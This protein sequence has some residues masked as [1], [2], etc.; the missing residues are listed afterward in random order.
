MS[1]RPFDDRD[2]LDTAAYEHVVAQAAEAHGIATHYHRDDP[3]ASTEA[4]RH[5]I[6]A[7]APGIAA[8]VLTQ[9]AG[10]LPDATE[11]QREWLDDQAGATELGLA[12]V[13]Y[14]T[15]ANG[16]PDPTR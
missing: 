13:E 12:V 9:L 2:P 3:D 6:S 11:A 5:A 16:T 8:A 14:L 4:M 10:L 7:A 1:L 15:G